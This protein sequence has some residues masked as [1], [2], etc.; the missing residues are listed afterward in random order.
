MF[1]GTAVV[2]RAY[3]ATLG[4]LAMLT[5]LARGAICGGGMDELL[6]VACV[7]LWAFAG[8]GYIVGSLGDWI[9][10]ESVE[11]RIA[12]EIAADEASHDGPKGSAAPANPS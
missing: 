10:R 3:A 11:A 7:S 12:A 5:A 6:G 2:A 4:V 1:S 9:V 8:V